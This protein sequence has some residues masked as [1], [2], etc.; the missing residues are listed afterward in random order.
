VAA[1]A[2]AALALAACTQVVPAKPPPDAPRIE[3][4]VASEYRTAAGQPVTLS[5]TTVN[6]TRVELIDDGGNAVQLAG[7]VAS[8]T[9]TVAPARS[10]FYVLRATGPGGRDSAFVQ[11]AVAEPVADVFLIAV[12]PVIEAGG[13]AQLL[14]GA[15]NALTATLVS[16][17]GTPQTLTGSTGVVSLKPARGERYT[18]T[19]TGE[20]G[21]PPVTAVTD[22]RVLPVLSEATLAADDGVEA[23]KTLRFTWKTGG[24]DAVRVSEDT[25]GPLTTITEP[26]DVANGRYDYVLPATLPNGIAVANGLP[27]RFTVTATLGGEARSRTLDAVV[28]APPA[29]T[30]LTAPE[31]VNEG[32]T[33]TVAWRTTLATQVTISVGGQ[34]IFQTRAAEQARVANG[35]V[36]LPAPA[37]SAD[38]TLTASDDRGAKATRAFTVR[39]V[40]L[41]VINTFTLTPTLNAAGDSATATWTTSNASRVELRFENGAQ[42]AEVTAPAGVASGSRML[43]F[44]TSARVTLEAF[45]AAGSKVSQTRATKLVGPAAKVTPAPA[46]RNANTNVAWSLAALGVQE[47]V[48]LPTPAPA[49]VQA[50]TRF[51]DLTTLTGAQEL[52]FDDTND[53]VEQLPPFPGFVFPLAGTPRPDLFVGANGFLT[54]ARPS[55]GLPTNSALTTTTPPTILAAFW[56]NLTLAPTSKV[57]YALTTDPTTTEQVL[58]VEWNKVQIVGDPASELTFQA[59]LFETGQVTF[60][61]G[62]MT[63][64]LTSATV[65]IKDTQAPAWN[66]QYSHDGAPAAVNTADELNF[67]SGAPADGALTQTGASDRRINFFGRTGTAL[68]AL[69]AEVRTFAAN[70]VRVTEVMPQPAASIASTGQWFELFNTRDASVDFGGLLLTTDQSTIP[71]GGF[72]VPEETV[73]APG[74]YLVIGQSLVAADNGGAPVTQVAT[75]VGLSAAGYARVSVFTL[76]GGSDVATVN[77]FAWD[78][79]VPGESVQTSDGVPGAV[80]VAS[81]QSFPCAGRMQTFGTL[82]SIGTPGALNEVCPAPY[83]VSPLPNAPFVPAPSTATIFTFSS[84]DTARVDFTL[85]QAFTYFGQSVTNGTINTNGFFTLGSTHTA[86]GTA[87]DTVPSTTAPNGVVAPFWDDLEI[88]PS[89]KAAMWRAT[90]RTIISFEDF[91]VW[92]SSAGDNHLNFQVH[93]R[94][95]AAI[96][97]RYGTLTTAATTQTALDLISGSSTTVWLE[98]GDG[99]IAI[100]SSINTAGAIQPNTAILFTPRP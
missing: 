14:W 9:A 53:G 26:S 34:P 98:R 77:N 38:Y 18:L 39:P 50:S 59:Q 4:F 70:E 24:A 81:G 7:E 64:T 73:V 23:G 83:T 29:I 5:F 87:N 33:F 94:D 99:V 40:A 19:V 82:G 12:P 90:D 21:T 6:A 32:G 42:L 88:L 36:T 1:L 69:S 35:S 49:L 78:A 11:V 62:Q 3:S 13:E 85:P 65:G 76:D 55:T 72:V 74:G 25:F 56:D 92:T 58:V 63:G 75:D 46:L 48:G 41:P 66:Q 89:G 16:S 86:G 67:L 30:R 61:Y 71:D 37:A 15:R 91:G 20:P 84:T 97:F 51:I 96:E 57:L 17:M 28:G 47:V 22:V 8:G 95:D 54:V 79:S 44:G 10:T 80:L 60:V 68:L 93:L 45:N 31:A 2:F 100:P 52:P 43:P 27:L